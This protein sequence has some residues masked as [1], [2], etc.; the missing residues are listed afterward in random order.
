L[1]SRRL[2]VEAAAVG[3]IVVGLATVVVSDEIWISLELIV[4]NECY[5][6]KWN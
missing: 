6:R 1:I 3:W 2:D 5:A 4:F